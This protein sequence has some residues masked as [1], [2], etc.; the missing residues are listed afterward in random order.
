MRRLLWLVPILF[1][2]AMAG[3]SAWLALQVRADLAAAQSSAERLSQAMEAE[4]QQAVEAAAGD[5]REASASAAE[6]TDGPAWSVLTLTPLVGDDAAGVRALTR[7]LDLVSREGVDPVVDAMKL[8]ER[9]QRGG[10]IDLGVVRDLDAPVEQASGA[11]SRAHAEVAGLDSSGYAGP[12]KGRFEEYVDT[13]ATADEALSSAAVA[14]EVLPG[15]LGGEG[16]RDYLLVFQNNAEIRATGGL[17]GSWALMHTDDGRL[18]LER[19]GSLQDFPETDRP[20]LPLTGEEDRLFD[21]FL[22]RFAHNVNLTPDFPRAAELMNAHWERRYPAAPLDGVISLDPVAMSYLLEATGPIEAAGQTLT[23]ETLVEELL[24][25]PYFELDPQAQ[26]VLFA[27]TAKV[28][29]DRI[30]SDLQSPLALVEGLSRAADEGRLLVAPF[31]ADEAE[32][33]EGSEVLGALPEADADTPYVDVALNDA[34]MSKMSY[35]LR[36]GA[37]LRATGCE[38]G[39]QQVQGSLR[40]SQS[41]TPSEVAA[42][43]DYVAGPGQGVKRG[44]QLINVV[45]LGPHE[46]T[47]S[48]VRIDGKTIRARPTTF[49]GRPAT[50]LFVF[51]GSSETTVI[52]WTMESGEGQSGDIELS[53]T[54]SVVP[55]DKDAV[56]ASAC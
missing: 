14:T 18:T 56:V 33:L 16:P 40:L 31:E 3:Y 21:D 26:D 46:G 5:L 50:S 39:R 9:I 37:E 53:M 8:V 29:F 30:T 12:V 51:L 32:A 28:I 55:G 15:L 10:R 2:L 44:E 23:A 13:V 19:Q 48:D 25:K 27:E 54:P 42:L 7:S 6:R 11:I 17:P 45:V 36:Y 52:N 1:V 22:G 24:S 4:D 49:E 41:L 34:T 47:I 35:Y 20:V 38:S 43:P